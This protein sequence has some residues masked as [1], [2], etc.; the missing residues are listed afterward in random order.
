MTV[1][2]LTSTTDASGELR[3][4]L[5]IPNSEVRVTVEIDA[6]PKKAKSREE[7]EEFVKR[8]AGSIKDPTFR[9]HPQGEYP[10]RE[11]HS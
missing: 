5:G 11:P 1:L 10:I 6:A 4:K 7:W 2:N 8:T 9:R 3:L